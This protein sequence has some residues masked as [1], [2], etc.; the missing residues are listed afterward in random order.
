MLFTSEINKRTSN[1]F[2][3]GYRRYN[4]HTHRNQKLLISGFKWCV[5]VKLFLSC[6]VLRVDRANH[7]RLFKGLNSTA[8][9]FTVIV[10]IYVDSAKQSKA[11]IFKDYWF[12]WPTFKNIFTTH[13]SPRLQDLTDNSTHD[14]T[15]NRTAHLPYEAASVVVICGDRHD[16][17]SSQKTFN[18][19]EDLFSTNGVKVQTP[20]N[21]T[22]ARDTNERRPDFSD[23]LC[24]PEANST[25]RDQ[26]ESQELL[27]TPPTTSTSKLYHSPQPT[28]TP[29]QFL[30]VFWWTYKR[31]QCH[32]L[33]LLILTTLK[34]NLLWTF[35]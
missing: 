22:H 7:I 30:S 3:G 10:N 5:G 33:V 2:F 25:F 19:G 17:A 29:K 13:S 20:P 6:F 18:E 9:T 12:L 28:A 35:T 11:K 26:T 34:C 16:F 4:R 27:M 31:F 1:L 24:T 8:G 15:G 21:T 14:A 23:I 32:Q